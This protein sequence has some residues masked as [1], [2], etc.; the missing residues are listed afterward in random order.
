MVSACAGLVVIDEERGIIRLAHYTTQEFFERFRDSWVPDG[1]AEIARVCITYLTIDLFPPSLTLDGDGADG[2]DTEEDT[3]SVDEYSDDEDFDDEMGSEKSTVSR[4]RD[5]C[6]MLNANPFLWYAAVYWGL[7]VRESDWTTLEGPVLRFLENGAKVALAM[8]MLIFCDCQREG[9]ATKETSA[10]HLTAY[11]GLL[12][13]TTA[14]IRTGLSP[15]SRD[16]HNRTP[17]SWAA[18]VGAEAVVEVLLE[19]DDVHSDPVDVDNGQTPLSYAAEGGHTN[20][21]RRL[22]ETNNVSILKE[23]A[24]E[25]SSLSAAAYEELLAIKQLLQAYN[26]VKVNSKDSEGK[27]PLAHAAHR[28]HEEIVRQ[29]L[30]Q[31]EIEVNAKDQNGLTPLA[32]A[33]QQGHDR[34]V[35][36]LL[37][38]DE[39]QMGLKME[40]KTEIAW[41]GPGF[42]NDFQMSRNRHGLLPLYLAAES[43]NIK[44]VQMLVEQENVRATY[45]AFETQERQTP[46]FPAARNGHRAVVDFLLQRVAH[47]DAKNEV[48]QTALFWAARGGQLRM[49]EFFLGLG[50]APDSK[51]QSG[52][53]PLSWAAGPAPWARESMEGN[54]AVARLLLDLQDG[55]ADSNDKKVQPPLSWTAGAFRSMQKDCENGTDLVR[56]LADRNDVQADSKD[57]FGRSPPSWMAEERNDAGALLLLGRGAEVDA[58]NDERRTPLSVAAQRCNDNMADLTT[59]ESMT[60]LSWA[61]SG[62]PYRV[63]Y[64]TFNGT[65]TS[66]FSCSTMVKLIHEIPMAEPRFRGLLNTIKWVKW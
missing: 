7:H 38:Q 43:G 11:F 34:I 50:L 20:I 13:A 58:K 57:S 32:H 37:E 29:L 63:S 26:S 65:A 5:L 59:K 21:V 2:H 35:R 8:E 31:E 42:D 16:D 53:T 4:L 45:A 24:T 30:E 39:N 40:T 9:G 14:L 62:S 10:I 60:P 44:I 54:E 51:D 27:T 25:E 6:K 23:T 55:N 61:A 56:L 12:E 46:L 1:D 48:G 64:T 33:A 18:A 41:A 22:L 3:A 28:G 47:A 17:L 19:R 15:D 36:L 52:R 66:H 49:V